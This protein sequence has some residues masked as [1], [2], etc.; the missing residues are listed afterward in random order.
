MR[1][2]NN[3]FLIVLSINIFIL[4]LIVN[5][6][7]A[8][9]KESQ[10]EE[11]TG[12]EITGDITISQDLSGEGVYI[13]ETKLYYIPG[14]AVIVTTNLTKNT[15]EQITALG[16]TSLFPNGWKFLG[17]SSVN[18]PPIYPVNDKITSNGT[19]PFEFAWIS[20]P[21]FPFS[22]SFTVQVPSD[23][24]GPCQ[25]ISQALFRTT[26][27][28]FCSNIVQ[29]SFAGD[30]HPPEGEGLQEGIAEGNGEGIG[31]GLQEGIAEG[32]GEGIGEGSTE[33]KQEG[34]N[35]GVKDG[36]D[37]REGTSSTEG[38]G[39]IDTPSDKACGCT[40]TSEDKY[41]WQKCLI[42]FLL[43]GMLLII[44]SGTENRKR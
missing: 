41:L 14:S 20:I 40:D 9:E 1:S 44:M 6:S 5:T 24:Q 16:L 15:S 31:E 22:F 37:S 2:K 43:V 42:D 7:F 10:R 27:V 13:N 23:M 33:G 36:E 29:T 28:Q 18:S 34:T 32:N 26:N 30:M 35:D 38:E 4:F 8:G 21:S 3:V 17:V 11:L 12:C 39:S 25:I 19:D